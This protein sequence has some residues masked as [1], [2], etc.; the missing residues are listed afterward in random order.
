VKT[1]VNQSKERNPIGRE[2]N[3]S[4]F[5]HLIL[6]AIGLIMTI[7]SPTQVQLL[8]VIQALTGIIVLF[9]GLKFWFD[10]LHWNN[11]NK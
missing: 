3:K 1:E 11:N 7:T 10:V 4:K 5:L 9:L 8:M 6:I 2:S